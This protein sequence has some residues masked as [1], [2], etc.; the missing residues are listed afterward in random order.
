M[1]PMMHAGLR[2]ARLIMTWLAG[3]IAMAGCGDT[4]SSPTVGAV[5][6]KAASGTGVQ[7]SS[8]SPSD[9][10]RNLTLDVTVSGSGFDKGS[11][12]TF[13][14]S[15]ELADKVTTNSTRFISSKQLVANVT[16]AIDA[17]PQ[18]YDVVVTTSG[19][20][21]GIGVERFEV[22]QLIVLEPPAGE[23]LSSV[24]AINA[25]AHVVGISYTAPFF[26]TPGEGATSMQPG[27]WGVVYGMNDHDQVVGANCGVPAGQ[28][29]SLDMTYGALW[30]RAGGTWTVR[31]V[32]G[33]AGRAMDI[34][35]QGVIYGNDPGPACWVP[36]GNAF[37]RTDL[38]VPPGFGS[39]RIIGANETGQ[40]VGGR[41]LWSREPGGWA[42]IVLPTPSGATDPG[43]VSV[44]NIDATGRLVVVGYAYLRGIQQAFRWTFARQGSSWAPVAIDNLGAVLRAASSAAYGVNASGDAVGWVLRKTFREPVRWPASGPAV[45]LPYPKNGSGEAKAITDNGWIAGRVGFPYQGGTTSRAAVWRA[46]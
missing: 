38:P 20:K 14:R 43:V 5:A 35:N 26:W 33:N 15:E 12:V 16:V 28:C 6:A 25:N 40:V 21:R 23:T 17:D 8:V 7:V 4:P 2:K 46:P 29:T 24:D 3:G 42:V 9:A 41:L 22:L 37:Q 11:M 31:Q 36:N 44:A 34:D 18:R 39:S 32:T 1:I 45:I 19:G 10:P 30:V 27:L 13:E